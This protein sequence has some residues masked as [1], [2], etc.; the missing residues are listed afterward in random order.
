M[1][2]PTDSQLVRRRRKWLSVSGNNRKSL[3]LQ[4]CFFFSSLSVRLHSFFFVYLWSARKCLRNE[5]KRSSDEMLK[6][7]SSQPCPDGASFGDE[8]HVRGFSPFYEFGS[9][10][11]QWWAEG[12]GKHGM[13]ARRRQKETVIQLVLTPCFPSW[14][15]EGKKT[16]VGLRAWEAQEILFGWIFAC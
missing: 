6:S 4:L 8:A 14:S 3:R 2:E 13:R 9:K 16:Q 10:T 7:S 15:K 11:F 5:L 12:E 1:S